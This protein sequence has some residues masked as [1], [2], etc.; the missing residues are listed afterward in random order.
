ML[1]VCELEL[2]PARQQVLLIASVQSNRNGVLGNPCWS[3]FPSSVDGLRNLRPNGEVGANDHV[4]D[5]IG[6]GV[7]IAGPPNVNGSRA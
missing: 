7:A 5:Q 1:D 4:V 6:I 2:S 3:G